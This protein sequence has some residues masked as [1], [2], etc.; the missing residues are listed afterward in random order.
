MAVD[1]LRRDNLC[2]L[3]VEGNPSAPD[4]AQDRIEL[5]IGSTCPGVAR[6]YDWKM[7]YDRE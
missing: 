7:N 6:D 3:E 4:L 2:H 1:V 5:K